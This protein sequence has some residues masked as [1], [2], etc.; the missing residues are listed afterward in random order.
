M[1]SISLCNSVFAK[2]S[3]KVEINKLTD[4][5]W[6]HVSEHTL[7]NGKTYPSNG[8]IIQD[9]KTLTLVDTPWDAPK[10]Q[11]LMKQIQQQINLPITKAVVTHFHYDRTGGADVLKTAGIPVYGHP[12]TK[13][14]ALKENNPTPDHLLQKLGTINT[15]VT[16][17]NMQLMYPGA[18]HAEDNIVVWL[19]E[20]KILYGGCAV[21][22]AEAKT[23]GNTADGNLVSWQ[24]A[25][26]H[27]MQAFADIKVVVPGHG[28]SGT[29]KLIT[30]TQQLLKTRL[31]K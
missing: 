17:G 9:G 4:G 26:D 18:A 19:P 3:Q 21:R 27:L 20:H 6:V 23:M 7:S 14:L 2:Q 16:L 15:K 25:M 10:T 24:H 12:L 22:A 29:K 5:V 13:P 31:S 11:I 8:L 1:I 30:H 28:N